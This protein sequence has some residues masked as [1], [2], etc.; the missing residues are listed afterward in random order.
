MV[1]VF[2]FSTVLVRILYIY[3][4]IS[5]LFFN[6]FFPQSLV[7]YLLLIISSSSYFLLRMLL[8]GHCNFPTAG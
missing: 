8:L 2:M 4:F 6:I 1:I 3:L 5:T 7:T